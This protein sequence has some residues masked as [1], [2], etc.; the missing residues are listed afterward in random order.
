MHEG[1]I[2]RMADL[3][4]GERVLLWW[5]SEPWPQWVIG[6]SDGA[7]VVCAE[8]TFDRAKFGGWHPLPT[9]PEAGP[10]AAEAMD[11]QGQGHHA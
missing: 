7:W 10:K 3:R 4:D 6:E 11:N 8:G 1:T 5:A 2:R 9:P